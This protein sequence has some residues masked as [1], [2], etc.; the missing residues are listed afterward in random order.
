M[1]FPGPPGLP[2]CFLHPDGPRAWLSDS[3]ARVGLVFP[4]FP[5]RGGPVPAGLPG[6]KCRP[7]PSNTRVL[8]RKDDATALAGPMLARIAPFGRTNRLGG[9]PPEKNP[10]PSAARCEGVQWRGRTAGSSTE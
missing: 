5:P 7:V 4:I 1:L 8:R 10:D 2:L 3:P 6:H 9:S